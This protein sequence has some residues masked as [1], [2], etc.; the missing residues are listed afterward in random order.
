MCPAILSASDA[1]LHR[2]KL[3]I[4]L[5]E[6]LAACRAQ[7]S[8]VMAYV[9]KAHL[10]VIGRDQR[11][12]A[13]N[14][15]GRK[16]RQVNT[17]K[18]AGRKVRRVITVN[19]AGRKVRRIIV[20][21]R[22]GRKVRRVTMVNR[23]GREVRRVTMVNRAGRE[24]RRVTMVD[25]AGRKVRRIIV[26]NRAGR[27][28]QR[29]TV[30][31]QFFYLV[32]LSA[33][34]A[35]LLC[36][37]PV[38]F[39][40]VEKINQADLPLI[41]QDCMEMFSFFNQKNLEALVA[42][43][44]NSLEALRKR[45][46]QSRLGSSTNPEFVPELPI[47]S[48][49]LVVKIPQIVV[50]P[51]LEDIQQHF[52]Q[53]VTNIIDT[54]KSIIL[55]GE[56]AKEKPRTLPFVGSD[57]EV[58]EVKDSTKLQNYHRLVSEHK[59]VT[60]GMMILHGTILLLKPDVEAIRNVHM[61]VHRDNSFENSRPL[62]GYQ[63]Q[64]MLISAK[65]TQEELIEVQEPFRLELV[66]G[67]DHFAADVDKFNKDFEESGPMVPGIP[68]REASDRVLLFQ[69]RFDDLWRRF[70]MYSSGEK[71]FGMEVREYAILHQ[72]KREFSL[73]NRY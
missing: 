61:F 14:Q 19:R 53:G 37:C 64:N 54:H 25:R 67:V 45:V 56:R 66:G 18:W 9:P 38:A 22:A 72:R 39:R 41:V 50:E 44:K 42:A 65:K 1:A 55:W 29:V 35:L 7:F 24:V 2:A 13:V 30:V 59:E 63:F 70:E 40:E 17:V 6:L 20:V 49:Y 73:L 58:H 27:K 11:V 46:V 32:L 68:A 8:L 62:P 36:F 15:A 60:R 47:F 43:T 69:A 5:T 57:E 51:T 16:I 4:H 28:V 12:T 52:A 26:V 48:T 71:L 21:N 31:N 3:V 34:L 10:R 33:T 23:A